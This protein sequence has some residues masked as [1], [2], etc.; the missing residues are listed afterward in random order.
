MED[1]LERIIAIADTF[2]RA[3]IPHSFGGAIALGY[4]ATARATHDISQM[5]DTVG[6]RLDVSY[7]LQWVETIVGS[8]TNAAQDLAHALARRSL[9]PAS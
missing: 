9:I 6:E 1:L 3:E 5:L 8:D 7:V 2:G 4:Y